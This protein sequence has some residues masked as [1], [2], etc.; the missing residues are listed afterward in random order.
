MFK[1]QIIKQFLQ[2]ARQAA[3]GNETL[4]RLGAI[5]AAHESNFGRSGLARKDNN[6][7][8]IKGKYKGKSSRYK[9]TEY[10]NNAPQIVYAHFRKYPSLVESFEDYIALLHRLKRYKPTREAKTIDEAIVAIGRSG[11]ATDPAYSAKLK[12]IY[13][14][15]LLPVLKEE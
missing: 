7:F 13:I 11:Y 5:Q 14:K 9:T 3:K 10:I 15:Y 2:A 12:R 8:G 1:H 4:A 6:L